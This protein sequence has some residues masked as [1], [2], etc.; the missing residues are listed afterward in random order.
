MKL[1]KKQQKEFDVWIE[2][3]IKEC[4]HDFAFGFYVILEGIE[5]NKGMIGRSDPE[6]AEWY[7]EKQKQFL[8]E[9][10]S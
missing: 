3:Y 1:S 9:T 5:G 6:Y 10:Q 4:G 7:E 2:K 8:S